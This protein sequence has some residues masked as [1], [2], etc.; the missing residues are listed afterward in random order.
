M[1]HQ[2]FWAYH[3]QTR[4]LWRMKTQDD[5]YIAALAEAHPVSMIYFTTESQETQGGP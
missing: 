3:P 5:R 4:L 2:E 1:T